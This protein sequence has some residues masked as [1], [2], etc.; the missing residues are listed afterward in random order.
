M[1]CFSSCPFYTE[2]RIMVIAKDVRLSVI[3]F[4][5]TLLFLVQSLNRNF[6][7]LCIVNVKL[8][9]SNLSLQ[10]KTSS[11]YW[12]YWLQIF[13]SHLEQKSG[14]CVTYIGLP[15]LCWPLFLVLRGL[16]VVVWIKFRLSFI[17]GRKQSRM[18]T[19]LVSKWCQSTA[20]NN[21]VL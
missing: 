9:E 20:I 6:M 15:I 3:S 13:I 2:N 8:C 1:L 12:Q 7:V 19:L 17:C 18:E 11:Q 5:L 21:H 14:R 16:K 10:L 4:Y